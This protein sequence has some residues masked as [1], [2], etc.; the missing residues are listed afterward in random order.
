MNAQSI[1]AIE[2]ELQWR[3]NANCNRTT[4]TITNPNGAR[5]QCP[6]SGRVQPRQV[7]HFLAAVY[8]NQSRREYARN[9]VHVAGSIRFAQTA[10][11]WFI[12]ARQATVS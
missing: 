1:P 11:V 2:T 5:Y 12:V 8:T 6:A 4:A 7:P 3:A 9:L 10:H